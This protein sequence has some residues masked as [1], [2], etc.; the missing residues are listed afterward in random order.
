MD[1][2]VNSP[3]VVDSSHRDDRKKE[4]M[5]VRTI[6]NVSDNVTE[7]LIWKTSSSKGETNPN[8]NALNGLQNKLQRL[9]QDQTR[10]QNEIEKASESRHANSVKRKNELEGELLI[11]QSSINSTTSKL[12]KLNWL[13][14]S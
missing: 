14:S 12:R 9:T 1:K 2:S 11:C 5:P 3:D 6:V 8:P 4:Y 13:S 7:A 10:L